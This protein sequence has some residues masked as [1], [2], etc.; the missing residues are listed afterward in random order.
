MTWALSFCASYCTASAVQA[1]RLCGSPFTARFRSAMIS[2]AGAFRSM[3]SC[4]R[5]NWAR[6][7]V[8]MIAIAFRAD[9]AAL[10]GAVTRWSTQSFA[11]SE[12]LT[13]AVNWSA[14]ASPNCW[15]VWP[16]AWRSTIDVA[17]IVVHAGQPR[18]HRVWPGFR[19]ADG[20]RHQD[21][22]L[23]LEREASGHDRGEDRVR[24]VAVLGQRVLH[25]LEGDDAIGGADDLLH[26][27]TNRATDLDRR[28]E[29]VP[30]KAYGVATSRRGAATAGA[31]RRRAP[32]GIC[33]SAGTAAGM[34]R[35][36]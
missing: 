2:A 21:A 29:S 1:G 6:P 15:D 28:S 7:L 9:S 13:A 12:D 30:R 33:A 14:S 35:A 27:V 18:G 3:A 34:A 24:R 8:G 19:L 23:E 31:P 26:P 5:Q 32:D 25:L 11:S 20:G 17:G 22:G 36:R 10:S 4:A 16:A